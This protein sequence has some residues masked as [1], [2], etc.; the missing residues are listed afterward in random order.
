[1]KGCPGSEG[2]LAVDP[3]QF[4]NAE[5]EP[6]LN[7]KNAYEFRMR[8]TEIDMCLGEQVSFKN[9]Y[10]SYFFHKNV[11]I[12]QFIFNFIYIFRIR[13]FFCRSLM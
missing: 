2:E 13:N 8:N 5:W 9:V 11:R 6:I 4:E 7:T 3:D 10:F 12:F 1:M